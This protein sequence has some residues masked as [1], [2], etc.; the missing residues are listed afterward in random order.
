MPQNLKVKSLTLRHNGVT[1]VLIT[2][3]AVSQA[4]DSRHTKKIPPLI[5]FNG[6]WDTGATNS[7]ISQRVVDECG[8]KPIGMVEVSHAGGTNHCETYLVNILLR[9]NVGISAIRVTKGNLGT[10]ADVLIGMDII[11][12]GDFAITNMNGKTVFSFRIPSVECIDFSKQNPPTTTPPSLGLNPVP[13]VGRNA[14]C[15][16]G[17]GKKYKHCHGK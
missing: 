7:A 12:L 16:C 17:S 3:T 14:P 6:I 5:I 2:Q 13:N 15:P 11:T 8:L 10:N 9:N 4:F 1:N